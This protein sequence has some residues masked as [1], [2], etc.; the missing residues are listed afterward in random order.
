MAKAKACRRVR[1]KK[2]GTRCMCPNRKGQMRFAKKS[3]C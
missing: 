3:R 1:M 2:G